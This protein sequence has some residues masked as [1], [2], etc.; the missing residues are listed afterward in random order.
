V[1]VKM[2]KTN[3]GAGRQRHLAVAS[4]GI[5]LLFATVPQP[6]HARLQQQML[7]G[8]AQAD[9]GDTPA[10]DGN[11]TTA[12]GADKTK[13]ASGGKSLLM[14]DSAAPACCAAGH[15]QAICSKALAL[16]HCVAQV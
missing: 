10:G 2:M 8:L 9:K 4:L 3:G 11:S 5:A 6:S 1:V 15:L 14:N 13:G 12:A 7:R 16:V